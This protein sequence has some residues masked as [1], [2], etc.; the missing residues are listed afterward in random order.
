MRNLSRYLLLF[1][2]LLFSLLITHKIFLYEIKNNKDTYAQLIKIY[3]EWLNTENEAFKILSFKLSSTQQAKEG[4]RAKFTLE[5]NLG[6]KWI[7]K[8][9][10]EREG[11][12]NSFRRGEIAVVVYRIYK[13]FGLQTPRIHYATL[14]VNGKKIPGSIQEFVPCIAT[15]SKYQPEQLSSDALNYLL[16]THALDWLLA[17]YDSSP[18]NFLVL[19]CGEGKP[20]KIMRIDNETAFVL[21]DNNELKYDWICPWHEYPFTKYYYQLWRNYDLKKIG[22]DTENNFPFIKF[23]SELPDDF[24]KKLILPVKTHGFKEFSQDEFERLINTHKNFLETIVI[25]KHNLIKDFEKF[26]GDLAKKRGESFR[27]HKHIDTRKII[28]SISG[29]LTVEMKRLRE[30]KSKLKNAPI[31]TPN[32]DVIFSPE[33]FNHLQNVYRACWKD[34]KKNLISVCDIAVK[35]LVSL[36]NFTENKYE[37]K[38]IKIYTEEIK[39]V[40]SGKPPSFCYNEINKVIPSVVPED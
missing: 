27:F 10:T 37:K 9:D 22:L 6:R 15:L 26:Y 24:F 39:R 13:L 28:I 14:N 32:I 21:S 35:N 1:L 5:D 29:D 36:E 38:A 16:K 7:F 11:I 20:D 25:K 4:Q 3:K 12:Y 30:E 18:G 40:R 34:K 2:I 19:S 31:Y 17:N 33:G 8:P 23:V